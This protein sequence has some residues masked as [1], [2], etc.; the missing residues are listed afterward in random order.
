MKFLLILIATCFFFVTNLFAQVS[1]VEQK[2]FNNYGLQFKY[3]SD[4]E[5]A[6][7]SSP[8]QVSLQIAKPGTSVSIIL[9][10]PQLEVQSNDEYLKLQ[11]A[12]DE[13]YVDLLTQIFV[14]S[15]GQIRHG[16]RC[17]DYQ[18]RKMIGKIL[19][20]FSQNE[21][22]TGEVHSFVTGSRYVSLFYY[23]REKDNAAGNLVWKDFVSSLTFTPSG[24]K[25]YLEWAQRETLKGGFDP[26]P[27]K[28]VK[29]A[30]LKEFADA[31]V[32]GEV[33][34]E[35]EIDE[36]G[37]VVSAKAYSGNPMLHEEAERAAKKSEFEPLVFCGRAV[38]RIGRIV[39]NF[40]P[41]K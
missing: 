11:L 31:R 21:P 10:S 3:P 1:N 28:L 25:V 26:K 32:G 38:R 14:R 4:W 39:Y 2:T 36:R 19:S 29:P 24:K 17:L 13:K 37:K 35:I 23:R 41:A 22:A 5:I 8:E 18:G 27:V 20:G 30:Y 7:K 34:V 9:T 6:D 15:S 40:E 33:E 16:W 12:T